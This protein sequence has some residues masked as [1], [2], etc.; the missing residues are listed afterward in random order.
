MIAPSSCADT[1][2][3]YAVRDRMPSRVRSGIR[4][5]TSLSSASAMAL[6]PLARCLRSAG[7]PFSSM[8]RSALSGYPES[9]SA[10][11]ASSR[12]RRAAVNP[13]AVSGS[14]VSSHNCASLSPYS[15]QAGS[16]ASQLAKVSEPV[17]ATSPVR[18]C[19]AREVKTSASKR[20]RSSIPGRRR[21]RT[22]RCQFCEAK[23]RSRG[24]PSYSSETYSRVAFWWARACA[25]AS[26]TRRSSLTASNSSAPTRSNT[27]A[28]S[29][30]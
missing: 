16:C 24:C 29:R 12:P 25:S 21:S 4:A 14:P 5:L 17:T 22:A 10:A 28:R 26:S 23:P 3:M 7:T 8:T 13:A 9:T 15:S 6:T 27:G 11:V 20:R 19:S 2:A 18:R 30:L 1:P